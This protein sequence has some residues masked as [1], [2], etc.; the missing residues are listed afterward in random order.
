VTAMLFGGLHA[1][2]KF[3]PNRMLRVLLILKV[4]PSENEE[5]YVLV[6]RLG[7]CT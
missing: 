3:C 2:T 6:R 5:S 4:R 7:I 1:E